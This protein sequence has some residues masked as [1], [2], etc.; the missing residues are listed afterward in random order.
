MKWIC[1]L[2]N[3]VPFKWS[4]FFCFILA[5]F[6]ILGQSLEADVKLPEGLGP[7]ATPI[8][9]NV[10]RGEELVIKLTA[11]MKGSAGVFD[12][13]I[14]E[15]PKKGRLVVESLTGAFAL[16]RYVSDPLSP[17][18]IEQFK[19]RARVRNG[20]YSAPATVRINVLDDSLRLKI[21]KVLDF[22][23]VVVSQSRA[24]D[25]QILNASKYA[26]Q[27]SLVLPNEFTLVDNEVKIKLGP[28]QSSTFRV[29]YTP[30][31]VV[32]SFQ[33]NLII[34]GNGVS[35]SLPLRGVS[36]SPFK[37]KNK[38]I[39]LEYSDD[40]FSRSAEL[41]IKNVSD[42][43]TNLEVIDAKGA[44]V[45]SPKKMII[46]PGKLTKII[47]EASNE[48]PSGSKGFVHLRSGVDSQK[49]E[50]ES[51][52]LPPRVVLNGGERIVKISSIE[53]VP[54]RFKISIENVGGGSVSVDLTVPEGFRRLNGEGLINLGPRSKSLMQFEYDSKKPGNV[55]DYFDVSWNDNV[56]R[57]I[58]KGNVSENP[59]IE[60]NTKPRV[61]PSSTTENDR[62]SFNLYDHPLFK[63]I[64]KE[65]EIDD[66]LPEIREVK[67]IERGKR[68]LV[69]GWSYPSH[70]ESSSANS[71]LDYVIETRV[72]R[73]DE[74]LKS[75]IFEWRELGPDYAAIQKKDS[76]VEAKIN[77]LS[78]D[79]KYIFRIFC[80]SND[81]L[82]SAESVSF[83]FQTKP[84][85]KLSKAKWIY[86]IG[87]GG[88]LLCLCCILIQRKM[89][90][91]V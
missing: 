18:G 4:H 21:P 6:L 90:F 56:K 46:G 44:F 16:V 81:G 36:I 3:R 64:E 32:G 54:L 91:N 31:R 10:N 79:G 1:N 48:N 11:S 55:Y 53:G 12:F 40:K 84:S 20:K 49:I 28:E 66:S 78:P 15:K 23:E 17:S 85:L 14:F 5:Q 63:R 47:I 62:V 70:D 22:G 71:D 45:A 52:P 51:P 29:K 57:I 67:L 83:R 69:L 72:H 8:S 76:S 39:I 37:I 59:K 25:F 86:L 34:N 26:F 43:E 89:H 7:V 9:G 68:S 58:V 35:L 65:R 50:V 80:E 82:F 75:M 74:D 38:K 77:G 60:I 73:Y 88:V 24:L 13:S 61:T 41:S 27:G 42:V 30:Q 87:G 19:Y 33:R 2:E